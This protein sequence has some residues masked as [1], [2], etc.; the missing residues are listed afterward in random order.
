MTNLDHIN[1]VIFDYSGTLCSERYFIPLG[2]S[3]MDAIAD[4]VFGV[5][6]AAG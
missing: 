6:T 2:Q 1:A 3:A 4:L 5:N